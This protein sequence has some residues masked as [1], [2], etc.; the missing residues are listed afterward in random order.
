VAGLPA[1]GTPATVRLRAGL[2][3]ARDALA[4]ALRESGGPAGGTRPG[5]DDAVVAALVRRAATAI[6]EVTGR[7]IGPELIDR[8]FSRHCIGK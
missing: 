6:G 2:S 3:T 1:G 7:D 4:A 5:G 8:I